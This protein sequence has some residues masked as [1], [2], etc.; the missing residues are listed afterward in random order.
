[1]FLNWRNNFIVWNQLLDI[2]MI[3]YIFS[4]LEMILK[5]VK[6]T[7]PFWENN[8]RMDLKQV[9]NKHDGRNQIIFLI[10]IN[11]CVD[12]VYTH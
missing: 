10:Q 1:M 5:Y 4:C 9:R 8:L 6:W 12:W 11:Q 7:Q 3:E 2:G